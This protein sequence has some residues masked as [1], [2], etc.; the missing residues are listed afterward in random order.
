MTIEIFIIGLTA[1]SLFTGLCTEA[2]KKLLDE[3]NKTYR[4]NMLAAICS[5]ITA[6]IATVAYTLISE[7]MVT[8]PFITSCVLLAIM[9]WLCA[10]VGYDKVRQTI[11]QIL[12]KKS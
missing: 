8:V 2:V 1:C 4:S 9:S 3:A 10:M 11:E 7:I 5:I 6:A 12:T